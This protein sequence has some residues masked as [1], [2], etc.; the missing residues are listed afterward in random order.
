MIEEDD[1]EETPTRNV[2]REGKVHVMD[3]MCATCVFHPGNRMNLMPGRLK[4][5]V[6]TSI[7]NQSTIACHDTLADG[8]DNAACRGFFD[9]YAG[10]VFPLRLAIA[11]DAIEFD[12]QV[13]KPFAEKPKER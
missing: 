6:S 11:M 2:Y 3:D 8:I 12:P 10:R 5:M 7:E 4:D 13:Q 1:E 9:R